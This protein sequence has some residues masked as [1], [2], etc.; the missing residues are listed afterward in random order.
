[1]EKRTILVVDDEPEIRTMLSE[2]LESEGYHVLSVLNAIKA[3]EIIK[4]EHID[5][6]VLD[7]M[8]SWLNGLEFLKLM[9]ETEGLDNIPVLIITCMSDKE[10][11]KQARELG[12]DDYL[13]KPFKLK[14]FLERVANLLVVSS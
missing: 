11:E 3:H 12:A 13:I 6:V 4:N 2:S 7:I 10:T 5:L 8:M 9:K 14:D 1:M